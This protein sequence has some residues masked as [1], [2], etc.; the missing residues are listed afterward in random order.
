MSERAA[1]DLDNVRSPKLNPGAGRRWYRYYAGYAP[2]F[3]DD[4]CAQIPGEGGLRVLD[5]W[6]GSGTTLAV[7]AGRGHAVSGLDLNPAMV[8][9]AK[10]RL[11]ADDTTASVDTLRQD[12]LRHWKDARLK[13]DDPLGQWFVPETVRSIRGL[14]DRIDEVLID[15]KV[16]AHR[17]ADLMSSLA[18]FFYVALF[19]SVSTSLKSY[20]SRNPTWIKRG[21]AGAGT[22]RLTREEITEVFTLAVR[23]LLFHIQS[24]RSITADERDRA[25]IITGDSRFLPFES[26]SHDLVVSSPPYL[27]RLDY[28]VGHLPELAVLGFSSDD[29][30]DLRNSM[31]GTPTMG[32]RSSEIPIGSVAEGLLARVGAHESRAAR[33]Y[34]EPNF[35]KYFEGMADSMSEIQRVCQPGSDVLLVVQDSRFKDIHVDL[36]AALSSL[37]VERSWTSHG[38]RDF[39]NVRSMAQVNKRAHELARTTKPIESV[40]YLRT[41][42]KS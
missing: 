13:L 26:D 14:A 19:E 15:S 41:P 34:Y 32:G 38:Q 25:Q 22:V 27:T 42:T 35:R 8:V 28:V 40:L 37:A 31:I 16:R 1:I 39:V 20:G 33:T 11:V 18:A 17:K 10:G 36:A 23:R 2:E 12:L 3:V 4:V 21:S 6:T 29:V 7:A 9:I 24:S 30:Q 5:P